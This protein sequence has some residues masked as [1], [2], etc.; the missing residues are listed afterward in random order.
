MAKDQEGSYSRYE[1]T[2]EGDGH[3]FSFVDYHCEFSYLLMSVNLDHY[4][5]LNIPFCFICF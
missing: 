3:E 2:T 1:K 4:G 5:T